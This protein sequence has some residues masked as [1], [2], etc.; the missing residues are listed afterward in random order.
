MIHRE[1]KQE[2]QMKPGLI[3][4]GV[5]TV[6]LAVPV[7]AQEAQ[8]KGK[9][10]AAAHSTTV[11]ATVEKID[12]ANRVLTLK[13]PEGNVID[14]SV[15]PAVKRFDQVKVGDRLTITY[16]ESLV[17]GVA[18]ADASSPLG[19]SYEESTKPAPG[20]KPAGVIARQVQATVAVEKVD[21]T[22]ATIT[23]HTSDGSTKVFHV[24]DAKKL[25]GI[26]PGD[27]ITITYKDALAISVKAPSP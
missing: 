7:G 17:I 9:G 12:A 19:V 18:K 6:V 13:G 23:V 10:M 27:K 22:A 15:S 26:N 3:A 24:S 2:D 1:E 5:L 14:V 21:A 8:P 20:E 11:T 25:E 4:T 16:T